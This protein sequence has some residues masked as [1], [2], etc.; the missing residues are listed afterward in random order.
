LT[1][2]QVNNTIAAVLAE[3]ARLWMLRGNNAKVEQKLLLLYKKLP[4]VQLGK[5]YWILTLQGL[6]HTHL[7]QRGNV[8][9]DS[10]VVLSTLAIKYIDE[11]IIRFESDTNP[12]IQEQVAELKHKQCSSVIGVKKR[13]LLHACDHKDDHALRASK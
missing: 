6:I 12:M 1:D 4:T 5:D 2:A 9:A 11:F 7:A 13:S 3:E 10:V 8:S